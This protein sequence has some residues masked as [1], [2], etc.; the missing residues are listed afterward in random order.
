MRR[1]HGP[2]WQ[3]RA[4]ATV[5]RWF[6]DRDGGSVVAGLTGVATGIGSLSSG[7]ASGGLT[8]GSAGRERTP[9]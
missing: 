1:L 8:S 2:G 7:V 4:G 9:W 5:G 3:E 6:T